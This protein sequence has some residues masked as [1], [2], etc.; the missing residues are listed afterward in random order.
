[1]QIAA[2]KPAFGFSIPGRARARLNAEQNRR[3]PQRVYCSATA[4]NDTITRRYI[5][6]NAETL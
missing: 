2:S 5:Y 3:V 1:M 6:V 4:D